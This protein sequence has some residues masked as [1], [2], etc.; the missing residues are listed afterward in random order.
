V[1]GAELRFEIDKNV[2]LSKGRRLCIFKN[3]FLLIYWPKNPK[4]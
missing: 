3:S 4:N 2:S 1:K